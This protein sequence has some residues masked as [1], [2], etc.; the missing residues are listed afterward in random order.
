MSQVIT[1]R[2]NFVV[3]TAELETGTEKVNRALRQEVA[4]L[5]SALTLTRRMGLPDD[6][7][8]AIAKIQRLIMMLLQLRA[9][10]LAVQVAAGPVGWALAGVGIATAALSFT[11][12][13]QTGMYTH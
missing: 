6:A 11:D 7:A 1:V 3:D 9:A 8:S 4:L 10:L 5:T 13:I 12:V 2:I